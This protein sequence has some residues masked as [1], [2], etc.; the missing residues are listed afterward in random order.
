MKKTLV[1][2]SLLLLAAAMFFGCEKSTANV[3]SASPDDEY[4]VDTGSCQ[5]CG[6]CY[7][8]C[9]HNAIRFDGGRAVI[10]QSKCQQ[11]GECTKV[12]PRDAIH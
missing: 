11:C 9:P 3:T 5:G 1:I 2:L 8:A 10:I 6:L 4:V 7:D 12:C